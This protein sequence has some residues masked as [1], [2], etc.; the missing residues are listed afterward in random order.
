MAGVGFQVASEVAAGTILGFLFDYWRGEG[1]A[2]VLVGSLV[3]IAVGLWS[4]I[5]NSLKLN[6]ELDRLA[7]T[8]GRGEAMK[9]DE[10]WQEPA[11]DQEEEDW[12]KPTPKQP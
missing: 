7:P 12:D 2:G 4:L 8:K 3:G 9:P 11:D 10:P 6:K 1:H 5:R